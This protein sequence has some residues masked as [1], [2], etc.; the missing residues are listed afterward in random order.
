MGP[1]SSLDTK[2]GQ[3][4]LPHIVHVICILCQMRHMT[5]VNFIGLGVLKSIGISVIQPNVPIWAK[6]AFKN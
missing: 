1:H 6:K 4:D 5:K 2:I 3:I